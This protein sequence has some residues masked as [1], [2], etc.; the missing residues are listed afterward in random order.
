[1]KLKQINRT[2]FEQFT[3]ASTVEE[4][5]ELTAMFEHG[6]YSLFSQLLEGLKD[7]LITCDETALEQGKLLIDKGREIVPE[8]FRISPSWEK[9]WGEMDRL[10]YHKAEALRSIPIADRDGEWQ[11]VM[12]NPFTNEGI[13]CYPALSFADAAYLYAYFRKDLRKNEYIRLQ[14]IINVVMS[15]GE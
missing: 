12:D 4:Y 14:K 10:I 1:M 2:I 8:P 6:G 9:V 5:N 13:S 15:H 3:Q 11:I 7:H